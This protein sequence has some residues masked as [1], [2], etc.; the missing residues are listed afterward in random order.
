MLDPAESWRPRVEALRG[1]QVRA[2]AFSRDGSRLA[3]GVEGGVHVLDPTTGQ[4]VAAIPPGEH[5]RENV[6]SLSFS[7]DGRYLAAVTMDFTA[8]LLERSP[9]DGAWRVVLPSPNLGEYRRVLSVAF[10]SDSRWLALGGVGEIAIWDVAQRTKIARAEARETFG[11]AF[12]AE[13]RNLIT[14]G[15]SEI[16]F[17]QVDPST[18]LLSESRE[19]RIST[20]SG[21]RALA[22]S[23]DE[24]FFA[25]WNDGDRT[26]SLWKISDRQE[27]SRMILPPDA[28]ARVVAF[29][30]DGGRLVTAI[31]DALD[32]WPASGTHELALLAGSKAVAFSPSGHWLAMGGARS[33]RLLQVPETVSPSAVADP[34]SWPDLARWDLA[35]EIS[36]VSFSPDGRWLAAATASSIQVI[37]TRTRRRVLQ[38]PVEGE[39]S[40][41]VFSPG[42]QWLVATAEASVHRI[43]TGS[44]R[45]SPPIEP[46]EGLSRLAFSP[47]ETWMGTQTEPDCTRYGLVRPALTRIYEAKTGRQIAW[48]SHEEDDLKKCNDKKSESFEGLQVKEG[49]RIDLLRQAA[50]WRELEHRKP[51][52][53]TSPDGRWEASIESWEVTLA[54]KASGRVIDHL[55]HDDLSDVSFSPDSR[56]LVTAGTG[57]AVKVWSLTRED[58]IGQACARLS[59]A[60]RSAETAC[61]F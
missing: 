46:Q 35:D 41:V 20:G 38:K 21:I 61:G 4:T 10:S 9:E 48:W 33:V 29:T 32:V 50:S 34:A 15:L 51:R 5:L 59:D 19:D 26:V 31:G 27:R 25:T 3:A 55:D 40:A 54:D 60:Q 7:P 43:A 6:H 47:D 44:W 30:P 52:S 49:G 39:L 24:R 13:S 1:R 22:L 17:W 23:A 42:G 53:A 28:A 2:L 37:D 18:G 36:F 56:W 45:E 11:V 12:V 8:T 16:R 57:G 14:A 58:L